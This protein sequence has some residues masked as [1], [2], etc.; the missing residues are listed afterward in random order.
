MF[1]L[2]KVLIG[3]AVVS[4]DRPFDYYTLDSSIKKGMRVLV[5]FASSKETVGFVVEDPLL[6]QQDIEDYKTDSGRKLSKILSSIDDVPLLSESL[7]F[8][9]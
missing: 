6:I 4:L 8:F 1:Y 3:R 2:I 7:F 9:F 5:P